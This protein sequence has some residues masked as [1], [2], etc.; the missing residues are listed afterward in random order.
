MCKSDQIPDH[1][2]VLG[3]ARLFPIRRCRWRSKSA[4]QQTS[5]EQQARAQIKFH[6]Q[7][8]T[9]RSLHTIK[10]TVFPKLPAR[11]SHLTCN[12]AL[13]LQVGIES[14]WS[15]FWPVA[16][17]ASSKQRT[18][19][20]TLSH[21]CPKRLGTEWEWA[22]VMLIRKKHW[23]VVMTRLSDGFSMKTSQMYRLTLRPEALYTW[24]QIQ[25]PV[26]LLFRIMCKSRIWIKC[27]DT[28]D[29]F[30]ALR[31][32]RPLDELNKPSRA[33]Q[34]SNQQKKL[35]CQSANITMMANY[36]NPRKARELNRQ[37]RDRWA[38][39]W[40]LAKWLNQGR[41]ETWTNPK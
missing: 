28:C 17:H 10:M 34:L 18:S 3:V 1:S 40:H 37:K 31:G 32:Y 19:R 6:L 29:L 38:S 9:I 24:L 8:M 26:S 22:R 14:R 15:H 33:N 36:R 39:H 23:R 27:R 12:L 30:W 21:P 5:S 13:I 20:I 16:Q 41:E 35:N 2:P 25:S 7:D 4:M 11:P